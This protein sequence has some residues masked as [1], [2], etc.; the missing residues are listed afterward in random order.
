MDSPLFSRAQDLL[1]RIHG[2]DRGAAMT[3]AVVMLPAFLIIWGSILFV[4][5]RYETFVTASAVARECAWRRATNACPDEDDADDNLDS[6]CKIEEG[7]DI[8]DPW[9]G[10]DPTADAQSTVSFMESLSVIIGG[11]GLTAR[12]EEKL[13]RPKILGGEEE[14]YRPGVALSCNERARGDI[15]GNVA[16]SAWDSVGGNGL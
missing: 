4:H 15:F 2:D 16:D 1:S 7:T 5:D 13:K 12:R 6:L 9:N 3:E 11:K 10:A 8:S 14:T